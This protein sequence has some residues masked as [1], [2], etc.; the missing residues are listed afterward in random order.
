VRSDLLQFA[1]AL[2][3]L[4]LERVKKEC[5]LESKTG[6]ETS[7]QCEDRRLGGPEFGGLFL[8]ENEAKMMVCANKVLVGCD[9]AADC[10]TKLEAAC[11]QF[12]P[13]PEFMYRDALE[14]QLRKKIAPESAVTV[15]LAERVNFSKLP[16]GPVTES[17][18]EVRFDKALWAR[19]F[20]TP[21]ASTKLPAVVAGFV[22][23]ILNSE[24]NSPVLLDTLSLMHVDRL[25]T[26][27]LSDPALSSLRQYFIEPAPLEAFEVRTA[28]DLFRMVAF[29][30]FGNP[31]IKERLLRT[32]LSAQPLFKFDPSATLLGEVEFQNRAILI[33][34]GL[35]VY[36][37]RKEFDMFRFLVYL[38]TATRRAAEQTAVLSTASEFKASM[39]LA[40]SSV[41]QAFSA[42]GD[43]RYLRGFFSLQIAGWNDWDFAM[44]SMFNLPWVLQNLVRMS[45]LHTLNNPL[46]RNFSEPDPDLTTGTNPAY[47]TQAGMPEI[48]QV[49]RQNHK[50]AIY[51]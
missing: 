6:S 47:V 32:S 11:K 5:A 35:H 18:T 31:L 50:E 23:E 17:A 15:Q 1:S 21:A 9:G 29:F 51:G 24:G 45:R 42:T 38:F 41:M 39:F 48:E 3:Q 8:S 37:E 34:Q 30:R 49:T 44:Q 7:Q 33:L 13:V 19:L 20:G 43:V 25:A 10:K 27:A 28:D 14:S 36:A 12:G 40:F 46:Q 2:T 16:A 26:E 4:E 22:A